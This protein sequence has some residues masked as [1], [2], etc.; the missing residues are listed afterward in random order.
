MRAIH[1]FIA[2]QLRIGAALSNAA[3]ARFR[4]W[5]RPRTDAVHTVTNVPDSDEAR[6]RRYA[7]AAFADDL[8]TTNAANLACR[9]ARLLCNGEK[10]SGARIVKTG[11]VLT[12]ARPPERRTLV[13]E[14]EEKRDAW[15]SKRERLLAALRD[16]QRHAPPLQVLYEDDAMA[17]V[18]KPAGVHAMSWRNTLKRRQLCLDDVLP[19]VLEPSRAADALPAPLPRHRLDARVAGPV[20]I[21][22]SRSAHVALG[23]AFEKNEVDKEY[24]A[25]VVGA[26][27]SGT[28]EAPID[29]LASTTVVT[30]GSRTPCAVD[31]LLTDV[32]LKPVTGRRHQLR[33]HCA[34]LNAPILG[35]DLYGGPRK[36]IGLFLYCRRLALAHPLE[37]GRLVSCEIDEP[38]RF[39]R[40]RAKARKGWAWAR[41]HGEL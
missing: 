17:V 1:A 26:V 6:L 40:H 4:A 38:R 3:E 11:D 41:D 32:A 16:E 25:L 8:V 21:A 19:L 13:P 9:A 12:L 30:A 37:P 20:A 10:S 15:I 28:V 27:A 39:G 14:D 35:D 18:L 22:K 2:A 34:S 31:G 7:T 5:A 33:R 29:G 24:G 36:G 23:R